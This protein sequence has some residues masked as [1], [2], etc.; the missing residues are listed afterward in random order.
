L[1]FL[2][3]W[4]K[5]LIKTVLLASLL[6]M[7]LVVTQQAKAQTNNTNTTKIDCSTALGKM[8]ELQGKI[9]VSE[10]PTMKDMSNNNR[11][12]A[13]MLKIDQQCGPK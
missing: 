4:G 13:E 6:L 9:V 5:E 7:S 1:V 8:G 12:M 11:I 3:L 2:P 10:H